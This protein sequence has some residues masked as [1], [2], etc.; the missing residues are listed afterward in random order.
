MAKAKVETKQMLRNLEI[1][2]LEKPGLIGRG[3]EDKYTNLVEFCTSEIP[4]ND[5]RFGIL[6]AEVDQYSEILRQFKSRMDK[7]F[8]QKIP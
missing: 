5:E 8:H 3:P 6:K 7:Q 2:K 1:D 4:K